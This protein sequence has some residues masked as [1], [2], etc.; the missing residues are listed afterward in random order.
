MQHS[1]L[2]NGWILPDILLLLQMV[3]D[4]HFCRVQLCLNILQLVRSIPN[5]VLDTTE[6]V[7]DSGDV[8]GTVITQ[9]QSMH[10]AMFQRHGVTFAAAQ[11]VQT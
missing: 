3:L 5:S 2:P 10:T 11:T 9:L 1:V 4:L 8:S 7:V 6:Y